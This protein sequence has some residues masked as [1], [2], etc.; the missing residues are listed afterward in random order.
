MDLKSKVGVWAALAAAGV[1]GVPGVRGESCTMTGYK[2]VPGLTAAAA[3]DGLDR[4]LGG[5]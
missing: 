5:R 4:D 1:L 2:S 3:G